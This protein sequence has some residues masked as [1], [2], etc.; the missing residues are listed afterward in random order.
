MVEQLW[1]ECLLRLSEEL[2]EEHYEIYI[3]PL[4]SKIDDD[5]ITLLAPNIY[6]EEQIRKTYLDLIEEVFQRHSKQTSENFEIELVV[7]DRICLLY[8]SDAADE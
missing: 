6:V 7:G 8:T 4:Q 2:S 3:R 1:E 5:R